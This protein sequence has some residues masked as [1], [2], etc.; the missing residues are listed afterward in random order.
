MMSV[1]GETRS[2]GR[3]SQAGRSH[4]LERGREEAHE[5]HEQRRPPAI[6]GDVQALRGAGP[7]GR[8]REPERVQAL[9]RGRH[10]AAHGAHGRRLGWDLRSGLG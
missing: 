10:Q 3:Q 7:A 1:L 8:A 2:Y 5:I 9:D 6:A 4:D